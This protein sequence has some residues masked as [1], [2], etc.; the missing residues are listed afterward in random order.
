MPTKYNTILAIETSCDETAV[1]IVKNGREILSN[2]IYSQIN[3]HAQYGGVVPEVAAREHIPQIISLIKR[4]LDNAKLTP[5]DVNAIAVTYGPGLIGSLLVGVETARYLAYLW[6]KPLIPVN[7]IHG[8]IYANWISNDASSQ[9][10]HK[11]RKIH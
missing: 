11:G 6:N 1:A 4:S 9:A 5:K 2:E 7:H 8:H 3:I 10:D